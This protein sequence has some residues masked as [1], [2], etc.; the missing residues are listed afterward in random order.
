MTYLIQ[1]HVALG[2]CDGNFGLSKGIID[3]PVA[4][5]QNIMRTLNIFLDNPN[6]FE[7]WGLILSSA[8]LYFVGWV[9]PI[10]DYVG[11]CF[12]QPNLH[13]VSS[14]VQCETQ[15]WPILEPSPKFAST[16]DQR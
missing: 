5:I 4:F 8:T 16:L 1:M 2:E 13:F 7:I 15:Q 6:I 14:I 11:F 9:E 10:S 3:G 12:T